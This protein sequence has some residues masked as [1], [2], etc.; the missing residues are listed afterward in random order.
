MLFE[1]ATRFFRVKSLKRPTDDG[2]Y[3]HFWRTKNG[4]SNGPEPGRR[5]AFDVETKFN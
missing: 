5:R 2:V 3:A 4:G 1:S